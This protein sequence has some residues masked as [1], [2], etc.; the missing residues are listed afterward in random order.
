M[1]DISPYQELTSQ[2]FDRLIFADA[3]D[4]GDSLHDAVKS[5]V[6]LVAD[7]NEN[8]IV[9]IASCPKE[10]IILMA[11]LVLDVLHHPTLR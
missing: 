4:K 1:S 7:I 11:V 2:S 5:R 3:F 6:L 8:G 9:G 10:N